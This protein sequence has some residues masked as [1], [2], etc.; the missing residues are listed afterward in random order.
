MAPLL[1]SRTQAV[2]QAALRK[3]AT[4]VTLPSF[5]PGSFLR[6]MSTHRVTW[7]PLV[8]PLLLFLAQHPAVEEHRAAI[9]AHLRLIWSGAAPCDAAVEDSVISRLGGRVNVVQGYGLTETS[10]ATH[11]A[12]LRAV[13][14]GSVGRL[15]ASCEARVVDAGG[16]DVRRRGDVGEVWVRG[17]NIMRGYHGRPDATAASMAP[18]GWF[19]TGDLG[20]CDEGDQFFI[21]DRIKEL[22]K[23]KG[24]Q[25]APAEL[26]GALLEHPSIADAAV[27][28]VPHPRYGEVPK[29]FVVR[30]Q[31]A[32]TLTAEAVIASLH[33]KLADFKQLHSVEFIERVPKSAA[34]KILR[35]DLRARE[36]AKAGHHV[37][38]K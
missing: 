24:F 13:V 23:V 17:P 36:A 15:V 10:P 25:V 34:G 2:L 21:V 20:Y 28:G 31:S 12:D 27:I 4:I 8:P 30:K 37:A 32:P 38:H 3:G 33:G 6:A 14:R 18:G 7:A 16:A 5:E 9:S 19:K 22:I 11:I 26:E 35:K 29:A 1:L